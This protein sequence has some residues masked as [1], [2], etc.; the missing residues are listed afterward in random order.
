MA[1]TLF[2]RARRLTEQYGFSII[3]VDRASKQPAARWKEFQQRRSTE[4][5]WRQWFPQRHPANLGIVTGAV[6]GIVVVDVDSDA[7]RAY[8]TAHLPPTPM[9]VTT[10]GAGEHHYYRHPGG[11]VSNKVRLPDDAGARVAVDVRGDGGYVIGPG[12]L[13]PRTGRHYREPEPWPDAL[14]QV[15]VFNPAW[16]AVSKREP[17]PSSCPPPATTL[18][19]I[20][21]ARR[22]LAAV[23]PAIQGC[24]GD[25]HTFM[26]ACRL[27]RG[28]SLDDATALELLTEW[29][30]GCVP[31]WSERELIA[32]I[33]N[34]NAYGSE[35][36]GGRR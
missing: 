18:P 34:A 26:V 1:T 32:K 36:I 23:P 15:P 2:M 4:R 35:P 33:R 31:P 9:R 10:G 16:L 29:N 8:V 3:P 14:E 20:E 12:S 7:G 25:A 30:A 6:S 5:E 28:F 13:H 17:A 22:Y 19:V 11:V 27:V 21:R 24:G